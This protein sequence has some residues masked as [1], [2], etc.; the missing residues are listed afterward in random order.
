MSLHVINV[1]NNLSRQGYLNWHCV[2]YISVTY[3]WAAIEGHL[4]NIWVV[5]EVN[6]V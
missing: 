4:D 6:Y 2:H 1:P 3:R 5:G